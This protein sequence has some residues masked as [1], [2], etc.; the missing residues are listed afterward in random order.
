M[1]HSSEG[2]MTQQEEATRARA[3]AIWEAEGR[4]HGRSLAHWLQAEA[5][6][7]PAAFKRTAAPRRRKSVAAERPAA[8]RP[9]RAT[10][11]ERS[12]QRAAARSV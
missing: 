7:P 3:Y 5:E 10:R 11:G 8:K 2:M 9:A 4:P 6:T 12:G 1:V